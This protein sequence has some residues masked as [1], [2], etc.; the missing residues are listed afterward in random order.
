M[1]APNPTRQKDARRKLDGLFHRSDK[2]CVAHYSC[3]SFYDREDGRSPRITSIALR[4]LDTAQTTSFSIHQTAEVSGVPLDA[5]DERYDDLESKMLS[6][7]FMHIAGLQGMTYLHW[8][9][10]DANYGFQAIEHRF[11]VLHQSEPQHVVDDRDKVD[12]SRLLIDIYGIHYIGHPRLSNL[13]YQNT[14][15]PRDF[16]SGEDEARAFEEHD[17]VA[18]HQTTLRQ[19]DVIA[20]LAVR[21]HDRQLITN[22]TWWQMRGGRVLSFLRWLGDHPYVA[23][24]SFFFASGTA[25][26]GVALS[27]CR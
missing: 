13:L 4:R 10:R 24:L 20:N 21:D 17:F 15:K 22:T 14:I 26:A 8:N 12:L 25:I 23:L 6:V 19:V 9:M 2:V 18:L 7:F 11:R 16:L 5:I 1:I 27:S 3:E